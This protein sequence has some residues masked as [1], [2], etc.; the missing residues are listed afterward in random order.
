MGYRLKSKF[1]IHLIFPSQNKVAKPK[2]CFKSPNT[3]SG[4]ILRFAYSAI[5]LG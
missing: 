3:L 5:V 4:S 2:F 1:N